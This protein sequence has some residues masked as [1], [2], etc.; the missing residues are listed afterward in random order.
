M[1]TNAQIMSNFLNIINQ[2]G[3]KKT[4]GEVLDELVEFATEYLSVLEPHGG[5]VRDYY[6]NGETAQTMKLY[7]QNSWDKRED[8]AYG[9]EPTVMGFELE[10]DQNKKDLYGLE[11]EKLAT[12]ILIKT[13]YARDVV[14]QRDGSLNSGFEIVS[15][16]ATYDYYCDKFDWSWT[17]DVIKSDFL[18]QGIGE[19]GFH[20]HINRASFIDEAHT[21]RFA[22][23]IV[24]DVEK[25]HSLDVDGFFVPETSYCQTFF[26]DETKYCAVNL[27][28]INTVE[29]RCFVPIPTRDKIITYL[30]YVLDT[31]TKTR[32]EQK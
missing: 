14:C 29:V 21:K 30:R 32:E 3:E 20:V 16:P 18:T 11:C 26:S 19:Q 15:Q 17:K 25:F 31:Q 8:F 2:D 28:N 4:D 10:L 22:K 7:R 24:D 12:E 6:K 1:Y 23:A 9:C 5:G 27:V 13:E